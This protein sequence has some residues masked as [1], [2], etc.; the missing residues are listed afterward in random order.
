MGNRN[1]ELGHRF[2]SKDGRDL[3]LAV[4]ATVARTSMREVFGS[5]NAIDECKESQHPYPGS[6][7]TI[8]II[9]LLAAQYAVLFDSTQL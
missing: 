8:S 5:R 2:F 6:F 9:L 4:N 1:L 7:W 3:Q